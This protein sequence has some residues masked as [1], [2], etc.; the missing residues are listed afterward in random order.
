MADLIEQA[1]QG[2]DALI[3]SAEPALAEAAGYVSIP[4][5]T[6]NGDFAANHAMAGAKAMGMAPRKIAEDISAKLSLDGTWFTGAETAG[7][8]FMNF[9]LGVE[10]YSAVLNTIAA[11]GTVNG[12][13]D[14]RN[15]KKVM[16]EFV[17]ANPTGPMTIGNARGGVLGDT[18]AA[19]LDWAGWDVHREFYVNNAGHQVELF[20]RSVEARY[21]QLI[22]GED[23]VE[24]P[25]NGYHGDDIRAMAKEIFDAEGDKYLAMPSHER[26]KAFGGYGWPKDIRRMHNGVAP[27]G[28]SKPSCT[29]PAMA[30]RQ[31]TFSRRLATPMKRTAR[32]GSEIL[33]LVQTRTNVCAEPMA[34]GHIT[35]WTL[36]ITAINLSSGALTG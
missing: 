17:S 8:G 23:A 12:R 4:K 16:V 15:G 5:N 34:H 33:I 35:P 31:L 32:S 2:I 26:Q 1:K 36:P 28:S 14:A 7:P 10:W 21:L 20:G 30:P 6:Q 13:A 22:Q 3:R 25:D 19:V 18:M 27:A 24:F 29:T 11:E 9:R